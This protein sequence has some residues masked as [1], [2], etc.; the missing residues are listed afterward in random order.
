MLSLSTPL[1]PGTNINKRESGGF[2][3]ETS[4]LV[5]LGVLTPCAYTNCVVFCTC[6]R[7]QMELTDRT[8]GV[9]LFSYRVRGQIWACKA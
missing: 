9:E 8:N 4:I 5:R 1:Y 3:L 7:F 6:D 2:T